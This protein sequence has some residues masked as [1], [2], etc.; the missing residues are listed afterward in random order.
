MAGTIAV[1]LL[2]LAGQGI[3]EAAS[4]SA[5]VVHSSCSGDWAVSLQGESG[6]QCFN[7]NGHGSHY[8]DVHDY[9]IGVCAGDQGTITVYWAD[10]DNSPLS[11]G[12]CDFGQYHDYSNINEIWVP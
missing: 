2:A 12:Q 9:Y 5:D 7:W 6:I 3:V 11:N 8:L 10:G 1:G 4:A